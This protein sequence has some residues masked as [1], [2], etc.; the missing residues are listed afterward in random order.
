MD[1]PMTAISAADNAAKTVLVVEDEHAIR[2]TLQ[3]ALLLEGYRVVTAVNGKDGL[4]RI[5]EFPRPHVVLLDMIMPV[6]DGRQFL[7]E[8]MA[9]SAL[10][11][12]PVLVVS[13]TADMKSSAG[14]KAFV[15]KPPDLNDLLDLVAKY[16]W[17]T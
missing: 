17:N 6:M 5:R 10:S 2:E 8:L 4:E 3:E 12:I 1:Q 16:A 15:K 14:A 11:P 13:A 9:D 7:D